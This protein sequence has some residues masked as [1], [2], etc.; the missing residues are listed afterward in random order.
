MKFLDKILNA[1]G[2]YSE[3]EEQAEKHLRPLPPASSPS[4]ARSKW[5]DRSEKLR[6]EEKR[7][8]FGKKQEDTKLIPYAFGTSSGQG[9]GGGAN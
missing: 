3:E 2:L 4:L 5:E 7:S 1:I 9:S 8:L 6:R